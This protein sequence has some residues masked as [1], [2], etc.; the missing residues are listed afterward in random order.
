M[1]NSFCGTMYIASRKV[2]NLRVRKRFMS[3]GSSMPS[4]TT[5]NWLSASPP[6]M[7]PIP[8]GIMKLRIASAILR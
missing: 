8:P 5:S 6:P 7:P 2:L 3:G 4:I 1:P